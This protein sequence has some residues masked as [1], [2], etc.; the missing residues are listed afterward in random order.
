MQRQSNA[1]N[2]FADPKQGAG[3][4]IR[5]LK[6]SNGPLP[7]LGDT[8]L[9]H[10]EGFVLPFVG[11]VSHRDDHN[12]DSFPGTIFDSSRQ[13][14]QPLMLTVG[15]GYVMEG[16]EVALLH[17]HVGELVQV[18]IPYPYA[19]GEQGYPPKIPPRSTLVFEMEVIKLE[20]RR[21]TFRLVD[22][23]ASLWFGDS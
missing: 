18:T 1:N 5:T 14:Q 19:Y 21:K 8:V 11:D 22:W 20:Q 9:V 12:S 3:I 6:P 10:Y 4:L 15:Q 13:R 16:W 2:P 23:L 17:M 7:K